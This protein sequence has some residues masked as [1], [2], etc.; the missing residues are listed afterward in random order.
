MSQDAYIF[1]IT[2]KTFPSAVIENSQ[3]I[4][5]VAAFLTAS[6][7]LCFVMDHVFCDLAREFSGRFIFARIDVAEQQDLRKQYQ[8]ENVP[9]VLVFR[10]GKVVRVELGQLQE[11]EA[12]ALLRDFGISHESDEMREQARAK[13]VAGDTSGAIML[14]TE[15]IKKHP[16]NTR[17]AMD[18]VQIFIDIGDLENARG[19]FNRLPEIARESDTGKMLKGQLNVAEFAAKTEGLEVLQK[20]VAAN[21]ADAEA[22]FDLVICLIAQH[23]YQEGMDHLLHILKTDPGFKDGA[24]RELMITA[25][26][27]I[28]PNNPELAAQ[29]QR[30][31]AN[32]LAK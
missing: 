12:R 18:M 26:R 11:T 13:H 23:Q 4:P 17:V 14:L 16:S 21:D 20:R 10:N 7:E 15:A 6:S 19:L 27:T 25:I 24:A 28:T 1:D 5:V 32:T 9:T 29:Y 8:I 3:K 30:K 31:M 2:E 22:R